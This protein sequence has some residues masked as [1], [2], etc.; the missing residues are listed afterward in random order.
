[1]RERHYRAYRLALAPLGGHPLDE[2]AYWRLK[3]RGPGLAELLSRSRVAADRQGA[4]VEDPANLRLDRLF[5]GVADTLAAL[6]G[7][8][9]RL[10]LLSLRRHARPFQRQV[11]DLG[12]AAAFERVCSGRAHA[13]GELAK[14][15]LIGQL[16]FDRPA[17]VVGDTEADILA[18]RKLGLAAIG[19]PT[20]LRT[21]GYLR[22]AGADAIVDRV[23]RLPAALDRVRSSAGES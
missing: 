21:R 22:D 2:P 1:V 7:R 6:R 14:A 4:Q 12:I 9:D 11:E 15:Q 16:G 3:R 20:G 10:Y 8:G 5:P 17:A 23:R 19:V 18:A 13:A